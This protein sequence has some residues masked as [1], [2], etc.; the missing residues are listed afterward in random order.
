MADAGRG[1]SFLLGLLMGS[2]VGTVV[3]LL[4]APERGEQTRSRVRSR[5]EPLAE[6]LSDA[7]RRVAGRG[8]P[9]AEE[10]DETI[11]SDA[12]VGRPSKRPS[13]P[14]GEATEEESPSQEGGDG[15]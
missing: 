3:A 13:G 9:A 2:L 11:G 1:S 5:A 14:K 15:G 10:E 12:E 7:A 6:R 4:L 8:G